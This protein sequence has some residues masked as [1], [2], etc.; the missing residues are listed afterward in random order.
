M[1]KKISLFSFFAFITVASFASNRPQCS[2]T[3]AIADYA[4]ALEDNDFMMNTVIVRLKPEFRELASNASIDHPILNSYLQSIGVT[5]LQKKF[6]G[7]NPPLVS[8]GEQGSKLVDLSLIY[9]LRYSQNIPLSKVIDALKKMA[10]FLYV[11]PHYIPKQLY[12]PNDPQADSV[13]GA[14]YHLKN[15]RAYSGWDISKGDTNVVIGITDTGF[16]FTHEDLVGNVKLNYLDPLDNQDN[17][18]DGYIDNFK[19][20]DIGMMDNNPQ[21]TNASPHGVFVSGCAG[22]TTDNDTGIAGTG[23]KC[24]L[25]PIKISNDNG[26]LTMAYEGIVYAADHG[27]QIINCSWGGTGGSQFGQNIVD[28]ATFNMNSLVVAAA[29]NNDLEL[30]FYPAAY[31]NVINVGGSDSTD[32][33]WDNP[34][35]ANNGS[36]YGIFLDVFAPGEELYSTWANNTYLVGGTSGTSFACPL[37]AGVAGIVKSHFPNYTAKQIG[38]QI[39]VTCDNMDVLP[40]N[41]PYVGK[42]GYG[43]VNLFRALTETTSPSVEMS[44]YSLVDFNDNALV[45]GDT[46]RLIGV[47]TNYLAPASNVSAVVSSTSPYIQL[48]ST[49]ASLGAI[50]TLANASNTGMPFTFKVLSNAPLNQKVVLMVSIN[51]GVFTSVQYIEVI[52]NVDFINIDINDVATSV[53]SAGR[54]GYSLPNQNQGLGFTYFNSSSLLY[55]AGLMVG[56]SVTQVSD[57]LRGATNTFD[58]DFGSVLLVQRVIPAITS[59]F[60]L[61]GYFNDDNAGASKLNVFVKH[62]SYAWTSTPNRKYIVRKFTIYNN[63]VSPLSTLYAGIFADW[64]ILNASFNK[65][66]YDSSNRMAYVYSTQAAPIYCGIKVLSPTNVI[67]NSIDNLGGGAGGIDITDGYTTAEK[68]QSLSTNRFQAGTASNGNDVAQVV[69]CGPFSMAPDDSAIVV[70]ALIAG[71]NLIDIQTSAQAAQQKYDSLYSVGISN[72]KGSSQD[73]QLL[74]NPAKEMVQVK[75]APLKNEK[76]RI[77]LFTMQGS[78]VASVSADVSSNANS[79]SIGINISNL[80]KGIYLLKFESQYRSI[81]KKLIVD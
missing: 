32:K 8:N 74:P 67:V 55:E 65:A 44:S 7:K 69:S 77:Q 54:I 52:I 57:M 16:D 13:N 48:M 39:K 21:F 46:A 58:N 34:N 50:G 19:G 72:L 75:F 64:D 66:D 79:Q 41:A 5:V 9:E 15:I 14:Q 10:L 3:N 26:V 2:N 6:P 71:D 27:C 49:S 47:F 23:F 36:N 70:F 59:D 45:V 56:N 68:Y 63:N 25:M 38:E 31:N 53:S 20:W 24:K 60:D 81:S 76:P 28:Y 42:L 43:R 62:D 40:Q 11:E 37:V 80:A 61:V 18:N 12:I 73:F 29:G 33:K 4:L 1:V 35:V 30:V 17:D 22:A 51:N 78:L